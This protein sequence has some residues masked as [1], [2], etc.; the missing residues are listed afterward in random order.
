MK[1]LYNS[2]GWSIAILDENNYVLFQ[3]GKTVVRKDK[4]GK[5]VVSNKFKYFSLIETA[6]RRLCELVANETAN[7]LNEWL[8]VYRTQLDRSVTP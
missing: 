4:N 7:D 5:D 8:E 6:V 2:N 1:E 3:P